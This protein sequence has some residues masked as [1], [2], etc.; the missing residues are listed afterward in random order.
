MLLVP[1]ISHWAGN[2]VISWYLSLVLTSIGITDSFTQTWI[3]GVLQIFNLFAAMIAA[4]LVDRLG[5]RTLWLWSCLGMLFSYIAWTACA[6]LNLEFGN[7][8]AGY[9]V[10]V[11]IFIYFF[12]YDIGVTIFAWSK[13]LCLSLILISLLTRNRLSR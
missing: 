5:R 4:F 6:A 2:G 9:F 8:T 13:S 7:S 3:N 10:V 1:F 12:H 11:F